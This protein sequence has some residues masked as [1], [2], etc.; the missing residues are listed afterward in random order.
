MTTLENIECIV[1]TNIDKNAGIII[2]KGPKRFV[3]DAQTLFYKQLQKFE[4]RRQ[5]EEEAETL[6]QLIQ[7]HFQEVTNE[8]IALTPYDKMTN[9]KIE[10]AYKQK[11]S[12]IELFDNVE[13][14]VYV[15]NFSSLEEYD[16]HNKE[17]STVVVRKD[18][19]KGKKFTIVCVT[20]VIVN[21]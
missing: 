13:G 6:Y 1:N 8:G 14:K 16:K 18:I 15:V 7:W 3:L 2:I 12:S 9:L 17:D 11:Q 5:Q 20:T 10:N 19:L 21:I 4:C